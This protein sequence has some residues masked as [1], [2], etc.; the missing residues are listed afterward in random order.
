VLLDIASM[1]NDVI[2]L[3]DTFFT[4]VVWHGDN[5]VKWRK[6]GYHEKPEYEN[7]KLL[8]ESS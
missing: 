3:L 6:A 1:K 7:F 8:L 4:V 2:L 5:M